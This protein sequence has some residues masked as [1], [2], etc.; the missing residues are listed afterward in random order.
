MPARIN[1]DRAKTRRTATTA[2]VFT[3]HTSSC[4]TPCASHWSS[5]AKMAYSEVAWMGSIPLIGSAG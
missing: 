3:T 4:P 2:G 5:N 1:T